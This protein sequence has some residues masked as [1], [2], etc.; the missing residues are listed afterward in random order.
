M[1]YSFETFISIFLQDIEG[2]SY[3]EAFVSLDNCDLIINVKGIEYL[4]E[5][6]KIYSQKNFKTGKKQLAYYCNRKNIDEGI[7]IVFI[8][9]HLDIEKV[10]EANDMIEGVN[11]K[12]YLIRYD[13]A[14]DFGK[15]IEDDW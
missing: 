2:K 11:I 4:I 1:M 6:K 14:T 7:Y 10:E 8:E 5:T 15:G 12:T 3:R 13:E 9:N